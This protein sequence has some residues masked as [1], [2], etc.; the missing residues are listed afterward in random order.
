[1]Y[2]NPNSF[3]LSIA[4]FNHSYSEDI[5][6]CGASNPRCKEDPSQCWKRGSPKIPDDCGKNPR[7]TA[8][9]PT[10]PAPSPVEPPSNNTPTGL[11]D[12]KRRD[13]G[14]DKNGDRLS[15]R[16][17]PGGA[18]GG[19]PRGGRALTIRGATSSSSKDIN[20]DDSTKVD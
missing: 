15:G 12:R 20:D 10:P 4:Y 16:D 5:C 13:P 6:G 1:M 8:T 14:T 2:F 3:S 7:P 9:S 19:N 17:K 11:R 18:A